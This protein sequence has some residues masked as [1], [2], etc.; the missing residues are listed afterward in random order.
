MEN[1]EIQ[2]VNVRRRFLKKVAYVAPAVMALGALSA[3]VGAHSATLSALRVKEDKA[4]QKA[5]DFS[6]KADATSNPKKAAILDA[7]AQ[8]QLDKAKL[9]A[10]KI[11]KKL[12]KV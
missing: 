2:N 10:A 4:L 1:V 9:D 5:A 7:K 6:A 3:P 12:A 8:I 11:A